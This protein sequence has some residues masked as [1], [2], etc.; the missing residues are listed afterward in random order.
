MSNKIL[1]KIISVLLIVNH[2]FAY[3]SALP[4]NSKLLK[5][6]NLAPS[7]VFASEGAYLSELSYSPN[8]GY[9]KIKRVLLSAIVLFFLIFP[10]T[11]SLAQTTLPKPV[12]QE[13]TMQD[14]R[15]KIKDNYSVSPMIQ[16]GY[17]IEKQF[18]DQWQKL[19]QTTL[20]KYTEIT[21]KY[22]I[23][24]GRYDSFPY[25]KP[26]LSEAANERVKELDLFLTQFYNNLDLNKVQLDPY[27]TSKVNLI[28]TKGADEKLIKMLIVDLLMLKSKQPEI[29][30]ALV[31]KN[32]AILYTAL[33]MHGNTYGDTFNGRIAKKRSFI[34]LAK[35]SVSTKHWMFRIS[36]IAHEGQHIYDLPTT[37]FSAFFETHSGIFDIFKSLPSIEIPAFKK[38][39]SF[40]KSSL[41][42]TSDSSFYAKESKGYRPMQL[43]YFVE[44]WFLLIIEATGIGLLAILIKKKLAEKKQALGNRNLSKSYVRKFKTS[45]KLRSQ[46]KN[47]Y[48]VI[49]LDKLN[50]I[51]FTPKNVNYKRKQKHYSFVANL[52]K[53]SNLVID[54]ITSILEKT[55]NSI[56]PEKK[57]RFRNKIDLLW[58]M[59]KD[60]SIYLNFLINQNIKTFES[61]LKSLD[62]KA[63][64]LIDYIAKRVKH[65]KAFKLKIEETYNG[66][67][68]YMALSEIFI[69][70]NALKRRYGN[71][72]PS[73]DI[74]DKLHKEYSREL[75]YKYV[76]GMLS[77]NFI[78]EILN[79]NFQSHGNFEY[80]N[81]ITELQIAA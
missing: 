15:N 44:A 22:F 12:V 74:L 16:S 5:T 26:F 2:L 49:W 34:T 72:L 55:I 4:S 13:I 75:G 19:Q 71:N 35:A 6:Q 9:Q 23:R 53:I 50:K 69:S 31:K 63:D 30:N 39:D 81:F 32:T 58:I 42:I 29:Y 3:A 38:A 59:N 47:N 56:K 79:P 73:I 18:N 65:D 51:F 60:N 24:N 25:D 45:P 61:F 78:L 1:I 76:P 20:V 7:S 62:E 41:R 57:N 14:T 27:M 21:S 8:I 54:M 10:M 66:D 33:D 70:S 17:S 11:N 37:Y 48:L 43:M 68:Y 52:S 77:M 40:I 64:S 80:K 46:G 36:T 28:T 67:D